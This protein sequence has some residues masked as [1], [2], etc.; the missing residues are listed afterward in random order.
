MTCTSRNS[1]IDKIYDLTN[2]FGGSDYVSNSTNLEITLGPVTNPDVSGNAGTFKISTYFVEGG[3]DYLVDQG[4]FSS[5][6]ITPGSLTSASAT[7]NSTVAYD[8]DVI[9]TIQFDTSHSVT[10]N[11]YVDINLPPSISFNS[12]TPSL[13]S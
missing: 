11:G 5:V 12:S 7:S 2:P 9:Y 10:T 3:T 4:E 13:A 8:S 6:T 1:G